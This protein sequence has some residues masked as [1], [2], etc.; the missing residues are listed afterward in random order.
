MRESVFLCFLHHFNK[1]VEQ[2]VRVVRTAARFRVKLDAESRN[3]VVAYSFAGV[4]VDVEKAH[5]SEGRKHVGL[6]GVT[7]VLACYVDSA[8]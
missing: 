7:V 8:G 4:V 3:I 5:C 1:L 2:K 6:D